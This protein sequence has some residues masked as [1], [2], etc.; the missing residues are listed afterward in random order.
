M[1]QHNWLT[2]PITDCLHW[3]TYCGVVKVQRDNKDTGFSFYLIPGQQ[4]SDKVFAMKQPPNSEI[5]PKCKGESF[6]VTT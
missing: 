1:S 5:E 2:F 6:G 3:C 4:I